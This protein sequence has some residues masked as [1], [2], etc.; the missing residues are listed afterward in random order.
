MNTCIYNCIYIYINIHIKQA[1]CR[2]GLDPNTSALQQA[3]RFG[4]Q[5]G[6]LEYH[7]LKIRI[8]IPS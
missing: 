3:S 6:Q 1:G 2:K 4:S 5:L 7:G 8:T